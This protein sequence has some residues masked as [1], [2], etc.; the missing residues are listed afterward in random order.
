MNDKPGES[1]VREKIARWLCEFAKLNPDE[2]ISDGGHTTIQWVMHYDVPRL[3]EALSPGEGGGDELTPIEAAVLKWCEDR[4]LFD[5]RYDLLDGIEPNDIVGML[6]DHEAALS[7]PKGSVEA[8]DVE[9]VRSLRMDPDYLP[10]AKA[11]NARID[12]ILSA[13]HPEAAEGWRLVPARP[14]RD[15]AS[16]LANQR[17]GRSSTPRCESPGQYEIDRAHEHIAEVLAAAPPSPG[18]AP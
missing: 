13:L 16:T 1:D 5:R 9:W 3:L 7:R 15:W 6:N 11:H 10:E 14:T 2:P 17:Q 8:G 18:E 12:R 4:E